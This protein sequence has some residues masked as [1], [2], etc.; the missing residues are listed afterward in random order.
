MHA[1]Q[2]AADWLKAGGICF[3]EHV[4]FGQA[5]AYLAKVPYFGAGGLDANGAG[6]DNFKGKACVASSSSNRE[7]R[8]LQRFAR[9]LIVSMVPNNLQAEQLLGRL[10]RPE[11]EA[12][13]VCFDVFLGCY[14]DA[15]ALWQCVYDARSDTIHTDH[16]ILVADLQ[17][18]DMLELP[19]TKAFMK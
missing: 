7:G 6:I 8:N 10:H 16:K 11:Q 4:L 13:E 1:L 5:L 14:E 2:A 3:V 15:A 9:G 18:P 12:D 19:Q 17:A